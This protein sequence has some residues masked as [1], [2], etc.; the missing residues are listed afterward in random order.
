MLN[1]LS[2]WHPEDD[3]IAIEQYQVLITLVGNLLTKEALEGFLVVCSRF[4]DEFGGHRTAELEH[5]FR[6]DLT[7][8]KEVL[9]AS[10]E[11]MNTWVGG[12]EGYMRDY[13]VEI[14]PPRPAFPQLK[15]IGVE[16]IVPTL[17]RILDSKRPVSPKDNRSMREYISTYGRLPSVPRQRRPVR[18]TK[19]NFH[20][21][22]FD[23]WDNPQT[24]RE[25]LQILPDWSDC[26][27]RATIPT[28]VVK[29]SVSIAFNGDRYDPEDR[30]LRF[31]KYFYEPIA[32]DHQELPGG[33]VQVGI[34]GAPQVNVLELY[35]EQ[36]GRWDV[37]WKR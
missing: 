22:S 31:Y 19:P 36:R 30:G 8:G 29:R 26:S 13:P 5:I 37:V 2:K 11:Y 3:P 7:T 25:A 17:Y 34:E 27:L 6:T 18:R 4:V 20:W 21:C 32:Q 9:V 23:T 10:L 24:T 35:D 1:L 12:M 33:A 14:I 28:K 15:I 16:R